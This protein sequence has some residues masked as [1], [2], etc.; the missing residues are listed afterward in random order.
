MPLHHRFLYIGDFAILVT[1]FYQ[2]KFSNS[3]FP[4]LLQRLEIV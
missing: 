2:V 4:V 3:F 1:Y